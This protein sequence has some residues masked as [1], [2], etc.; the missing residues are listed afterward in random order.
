MIL[1]LW[2]K[3]TSEQ[4]SGIIIGS[5]GYIMT[6]NH[7]IESALVGT[8]NDI[9]QVQNRVILPNERKSLHGKSCR[10]RQQTDLAVLKIEKNNL[11]AVEF[12][13][14]DEV[15]IGELAVQ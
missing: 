8:S 4:G 7:V 13:N 5:D 2:H 3:E 6:N 11:P 1:V 12:G 14:S 15:K 10:Q 9:T